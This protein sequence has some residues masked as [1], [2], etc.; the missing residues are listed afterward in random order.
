MLS[1]LTVAGMGIAAAIILAP[2][3]NADDI[4]MTSGNKVS[5][6][7]TAG[8]NIVYPDGTGGNPFVMWT[9]DC[10]P[11]YGTW[12]DTGFVRSEDGKDVAWYNTDDGKLHSGP[13]DDGLSSSSRNMMNHIRETKKAAAA[14]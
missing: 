10:K 5:P 6:G 13:Y 7:T 12:T 3:S 2:L 4:D 9:E 8:P 1:K 11:V 14:E